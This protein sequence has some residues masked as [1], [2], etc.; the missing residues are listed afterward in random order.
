MANASLQIVDQVILIKI[1]QSRRIDVLQYG[2]LLNSPETQMYNYTHIPCMTTRNVPGWIT[3]RGFGRTA[4]WRRRNSRRLQAL[5]RVAT[6]CRE[7][8]TVGPRPITWQIGVKCAVNREPS[9][10]NNCVCVCV[11][12]C[13]VSVLG[14]L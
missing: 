2:R 1:K 7:R 12:V 8:W 6:V 5:S 9:C 10:I 11:C 3:L 14:L 4:S 13:I